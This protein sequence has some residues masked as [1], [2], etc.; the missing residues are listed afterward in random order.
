[1]A[2]EKSVKVKYTEIEVIS[3]SWIPN[4]EYNIYRI[5]GRVG[6]SASRP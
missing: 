2:S 6:D 3:V 5:I 1:M 4:K